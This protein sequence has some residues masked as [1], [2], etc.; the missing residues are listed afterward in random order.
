MDKAK[1]TFYH[2]FLALVFLLMFLPFITTFNEFLTHWM[3]NFGWYRVIEEKVVPLEVR[4]IIATLKIV[5]IDAAGSATSI[6]VLKES[7]WQRM[8]I[9]WN[10]V[11]WQSGILLI[12]TMLTGIQGNY[13]LGSKIETIVI[14]C[15]GTFLVNIVRMSLVIIIFSY[16]GHLP[17]LI[18]HD[19]FANIAI[20]IWLFIFWWFVYKYVLEDNSKESPSY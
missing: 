16:F 2:L 14:G 11:G 12:F 8:E 13:K 5:H 15:L 10:C 7:T 4:T 19:Y 17:A 18:F 3:L 9:S 1:K 20:I 6:S